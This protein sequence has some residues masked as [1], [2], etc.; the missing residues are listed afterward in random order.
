MINSF[1]F[2]SLVSKKFIANQSDEQMNTVQTRK[3]NSK[4]NKP[5]PSQSNSISILLVPIHGAIQVC[6]FNVYTRNNLMKCSHQPSLKNH[7][8]PLHPNKVNGCIE[9][10]PLQL[11]TALHENQLTSTSPNMERLQNCCPQ[12]IP[13]RKK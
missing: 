1:H 9:G 8:V 12:S 11:P 2:I 7:T 3:E 5:Q 10:N 13:W 6:Q 4:P